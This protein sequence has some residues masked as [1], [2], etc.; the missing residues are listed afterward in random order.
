MLGLCLS[1]GGT[2]ASRINRAP[3]LEAD[4][5][6]RVLRVAEALALRQRS[7]RTAGQVAWLHLSPR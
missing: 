7:V 5:S 6:K 3:L 1:P 2:D 4:L